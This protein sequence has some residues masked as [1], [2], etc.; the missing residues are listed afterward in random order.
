MLRM[1][2]SGFELNGVMVAGTV[3]PPR[4]V[5]PWEAQ[6]RIDVETLVAWAFQDQRVTNA[7]AG[8]NAVEAQAAGL[9]WQNRA[10]CGCAR[11][12]Q[13]GRLGRQVDV[14]PGQSHSDVHPVAEAVLACIEASAARDVLLPWARSGARPGGWAVPARWVEPVNGWVDG[15]RFHKAAP[16]YELIGGGAGGQRRALPVQMRDPAAALAE[17]DARR[18]IYTEWWDAVAGLGFDLSMHNLGFVVD[19]PVS[20]R[21]PWADMV[22]LSLAPVPVA[23]PDDAVVLWMARWDALSVQMVGALDRM[24]GHGV[25]VL[26]VDEA[27]A[28]ALAMDVRAVPTAMVLRGGRAVVST[29]GVQNERALRRWIDRAAAMGA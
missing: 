26:D 7:A 12:E 14:S 8:L 5:W 1:T 4:R 17:V 9:P 15:E 28:A 25:L 13:I 24:D 18:A 11:I 16:V 21:E 2:G 22:A 19:R 6:G 10:A 23:V 29:V 27:P 3:P 20:P